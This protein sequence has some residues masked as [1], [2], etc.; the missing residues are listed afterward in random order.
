MTSRITSSGALP[1][2]LTPMDWRKPAAA[3]RSCRLDDFKDFEGFCSCSIGF[4]AMFMGFNTKFSSP[5][6][7]STAPRLLQRLAKDLLHVLGRSDHE[8]R[9][10]KARVA[11]RPSS[12]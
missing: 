8:I 6:T 10:R 1:L 9:S 11:C 5:S 12:C 4:H 7:V 3:R 2:V